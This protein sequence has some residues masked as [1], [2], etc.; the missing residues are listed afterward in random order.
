MWQFWLIV[1]GVFIIIEIAT[2]NFLVFWLGVG[3]LFAM[4]ASFFIEDILI[5][6][7][8]FVISSALLIFLTKPLVN[9]FIKKDGVATNAY[10]IIGKHGIVTEEISGALGKGQVKVGTEIWSAKAENNLNIS[11][12]TEIEILA[13]EGV[14]VIVKPTHIISTLQSTHQ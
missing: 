10:S 14:K 3:S 1:S 6:S 12:G 8:V 9:K 7:A 11:V 13:I 4:I 5:Q 2:V